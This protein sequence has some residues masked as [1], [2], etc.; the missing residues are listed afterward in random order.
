[1]WPGFFQPHNSCTSPCTSSLRP[2]IQSLPFHVFCFSKSVGPRSSVPFDS[3]NARSFGI[4]KQLS[5]AYLHYFLCNL[6]NTEKITVNLNRASVTKLCL[7]STYWAVSSQTNICWPQIDN[8]GST[9]PVF[10]VWKLRVEEETVSV[11]CCKNRI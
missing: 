3:E 7:M 5:R 11:E 4:E 9:I 6:I 10:L 1:M 8:M 2:S